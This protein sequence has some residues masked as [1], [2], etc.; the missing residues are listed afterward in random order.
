MF[1]APGF[2]VPGSGFLS[3]FSILDTSFLNLCFFYDLNHRF[4]QFEPSEPCDCISFDTLRKRF[5]AS[6]LYI[7]KYGIGRIF[8]ITF[9]ALF[10]T[11]SIRAI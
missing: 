1:E 7:K 2:E 4:I 8:I 6:R 3:C 11:Y 5:Y 9:F 10:C